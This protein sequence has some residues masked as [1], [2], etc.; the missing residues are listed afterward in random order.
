MLLDVDR[1]LTQPSY[2]WMDWSNGHQRR[3]FGV[4]DCIAL[5]KKTRRRKFSG[6]AALR[7]NK[8]SP[9]SKDTSSIQTIA[10]SA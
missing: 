7:G 4:S 5:Y 2:P 9:F 6:A 10:W 1:H 8:N 3:E